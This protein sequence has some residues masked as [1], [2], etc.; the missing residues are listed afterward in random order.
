MQQSG[1][2]GKAKTAGV[3]EVV[4]ARS[5]SV[6]SEVVVARSVTGEVSFFNGHEG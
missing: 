1:S 5:A 2:G 4:V 6:V 3:P